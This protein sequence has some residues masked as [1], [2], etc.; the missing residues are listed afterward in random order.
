MSRC[1]EG[2]DRNQ[3]TLFPDRLEDWIDEDNSDRVI[4]AFVAG[5]ELDAWD[6]SAPRRL[7]PAPPRQ[8]PQF[9]RHCQ[10]QWHAKHDRHNHSELAEARAAT[11]KVDDTI[12]AGS[13]SQA[14]AF[15][16]LSKRSRHV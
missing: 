15:I 11:T 4:D 1:I 7:Q 12:R 14:H 13:L 16:L 6:L 9:L 3:V 8:C 5:L 2:I 10:N